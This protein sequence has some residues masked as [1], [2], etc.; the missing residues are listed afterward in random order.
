MMIEFLSRRKSEM[1][2]SLK[3]AQRT[4]NGGVAWARPLTLRQQLYSFFGAREEGSQLVEMAVVAPLLLVILTGMASFGMALYSQQQLGLATANAAQAV[5]T[6]ASYITNPC[7]SVEAD[8]TSGLPNWTA[9]SFNY[10]ITI[11]MVTSGTT[12]TQTDTWKGTSYPADCT[13]TDLTDLTSTPAQFH[14]FTLKVTYPYSWFPIM[15]WGSYGSTIK[16]SGN[17]TST[18]AAMIQ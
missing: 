8:V 2:E 12:T 13:T 9:A 6:G 18:Q 16:P 17:L 5:A 7:Q 3:V 10:T 4:P 15:N 1:R 11:T 14:P